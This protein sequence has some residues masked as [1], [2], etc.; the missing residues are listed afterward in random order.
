MLSHGP[1]TDRLP[2]ASGRA[3][4]RVRRRAGAGPAAGAAAR[5]PRHREPGCAEGGVVARRS[6]R[7]GRAPAPAAPRDPARQA[8]A[9]RHR[10]AAARAADAQA[11]ARRPRAPH[12][13]VQRRPRRH[14]PPRR[15]ARRRA[16][17]GAGRRQPA[18]RRPPAR[19]QP[20]APRLPAAAP[21]HRVLD[22][23]AVPRRRPSRELRP[24]GVP[25]LP[26][27]RHAAPAAGE[28]GQAQLAGPHVPA[29]PHGGAP[30]RRLPGARAAHR[31]RHACSPSPPTAA[32]SWPGSTTSAGAAARRRGSAA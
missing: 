32:T 16:R 10:R 19:A 8:L 7:R 14:P 5:D 2:A 25:V 27:P 6:R 23:R 18:R 31:G 22:A 11:H 20:A 17:L 9:H 12:A 29:R 24:G 4:R 1:A 21:Q 13:R 28:L 15:R 3:H 30:P 26:R